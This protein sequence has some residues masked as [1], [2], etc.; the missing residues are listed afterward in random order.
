ML[1]VR[2]SSKKEKAEWELLTQQ[3]TEKLGDCNSD[4]SFGD[5]DERY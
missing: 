3:I 2:V 5:V 4:M 1:P